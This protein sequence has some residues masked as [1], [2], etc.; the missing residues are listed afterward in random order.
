MI[1]DIIHT[2]ME[3]DRQKFEDAIFQN[4]SKILESVIINLKK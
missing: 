3:I 4:E 2:A 1:I